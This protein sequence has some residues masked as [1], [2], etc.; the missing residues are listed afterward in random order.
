MS[1]IPIALDM[2]LLLNH[3][4]RKYIT[5]NPIKVP[6]FLVTGSTGSGKSTFALLLLG[7][8]ALYQPDM[9][10]FIADYKNSTDYE[11]AD[12][13][14]SYYVYKNC[15]K[16]LDTFYDRFIQRL[17]KSDM[18]RHGLYLMFDEYAAFLNSQ[19]KKVA[20]HHKSQLADILMLGRTLNV[21]VIVAIQR[22]DADFFKGNRENF[23]LRVLLGNASAEIVN[24]S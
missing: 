3:N 15:S 10:L 8:L 2:P 19:D 16:G 13:K 5:W 21:H 18:D 12:G 24:I 17:N 4:I 6:H 9:E 20:D 7:K 14:E 1:D 11:F 23:G 22:P